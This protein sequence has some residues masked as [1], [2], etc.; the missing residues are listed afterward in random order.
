[1]FGFGKKEA[2]D[3]TQSSTDRDKIF[4]MFGGLPSSSGV[5]VNVENALG[6]P[7]IWAAVNFLSGTLA[8]LPLHAYQ[9]SRTGSQS[10][11]AGR[12]MTSQ[13]WVPVRS[14]R[15]SPSDVVAMGAA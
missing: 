11:S 12:L 14:I 7:A 9:K 4:A 15:T 5:S 1:M 2:R 10:L 6:V 3:I 13:R 8:G